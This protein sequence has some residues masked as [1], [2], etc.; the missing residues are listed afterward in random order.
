MTIPEQKTLGETQMDKKI[1]ALTLIEYNIDSQREKLKELEKYI[2]LIYE[3]LSG[4]G[5][6]KCDNAE[7]GEKCNGKL[8]II[9]SNIK[10]NTNIIDN[11]SGFANH[12]LS[13]IE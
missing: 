7:E 5:V 8:D 11:I 9:L 1:S 6:D 12:I 10:D 13:Y 2:E 4:Y 3:I